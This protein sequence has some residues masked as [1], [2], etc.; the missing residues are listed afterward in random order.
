MKMEKK[1]AFVFYTCVK[2]KSLYEMPAY[3][4]R[5]D[6][7]KERKKKMPTLT[8]TLEM[9]IC[10]VDCL[11][12]S[13]L[14]ILSVP[15]RDKTNS[16]AGTASTVT[17]SSPLPMLVISPLLTVSVP[18]TITKPTSLMFR[19]DG[20]LLP[21]VESITMAGWP[22]GFQRREVN[23]GQG[24]V[25]HENPVKILRPAVTTRMEMPRIILK[26]IY[27]LDL[28]VDGH[29]WLHIQSGAP[30]SVPQSHR[31]RWSCSV[32]QKMK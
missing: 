30:Q 24:P 29:W 8:C 11:W 18:D 15:F 28:T 7:C 9:D 13:V 20:P 2:L 12:N 19:E 5:I 32:L 3:I 23:G 10:V 31:W 25:S 17:K 16:P 6:K 22:V 21:M 1:L 27:V 14:D 4:P 26:Y